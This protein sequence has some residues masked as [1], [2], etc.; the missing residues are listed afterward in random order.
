MLQMPINKYLDALLPLRCAVHARCVQHVFSTTHTQVKKY[1]A[2]RSCESAISR[3]TSAM[4]LVSCACRKKKSSSHG[5]WGHHDTVTD[6]GHSVQKESTHQELRSC[7]GAFSPNVFAPE[8]HFLLL[9]IPAILLVDKNKIQVV[10]YGEFVAGV[11]VRRR[12][13]IR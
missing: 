6:T 13:I 3:P 9:E 8:N 5:A 10:L 2:E 12:E 4:R 11:L 1:P 7:F